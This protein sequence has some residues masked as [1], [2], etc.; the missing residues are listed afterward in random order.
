[1][2]ILLVEPAKAA[3]TFGG[4]DVSLFEPLALEYLAAAVKADHDARILDLRLDHDLRGTLERFRPDV[5]GITAYTV[6]VNTVRG[7][8][9]ETK[10][11]NPETLTVVGGH[12]ATLLPADF[13][14][15]SIDVVVMG[16][17]VASF[18]EI[19]ARRERGRALTGIP[20]TAVRGPEG[21]SYSSPRPLLDLDALP[22]PERSLTAP[23][24][25]HYY[26]DWMR[27]LASMRTST[28]CP[29]RCSF[30]ALWKLAGGRYLRRRPEAIVDELA[31]IEQE[32]VFFADDESL[33][34]ARRMMDLAR[35]IQAAGLR[36]RFFLYGRSDTIARHPDLVEAWKRIGLE[37]VFV[38]L[39]FATDAN[40][41]YIRKSSTA[42][43]NDA[44]VRVLQSLDIEIYASFIVRP[45]FDRGD[46]AALRAYC[47]QLGLSYASF[48][49]LTPLPGTDLFE[50]VRDRL[51]THDYDYFDFIHTLLP[52]TL[53]LR[54]FYAEYCDLYRKAVSPMKQLAFLARHRWRDIPPLLARS[55]RLLGRLRTLYLDYETQGG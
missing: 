15:A 1:M 31:T 32:F 8:F 51:I 40:L 16:E 13:D 3:S 55:P 20:G 19:V 29:F 46:F 43:D 23:Y 6:H 35:R 30:C 45:E 17:G 25:E 41:Q 24:R 53:P 36:K 48:A 12:H 52:T 34:D 33:V 42:K 27:P 38:G 11:W 47:R 28:G 39:E 50:E 44:A 5:V 22:L 37:R 10:R 54:D 4:E 26:C 14:R 2:R 9:D 21:L 18:R 49:V 7:L